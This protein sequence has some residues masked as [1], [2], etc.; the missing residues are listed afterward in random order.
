MKKGSVEGEARC[1]RAGGT[2]SRRSETLSG[3]FVKNG[4]CEKRFSCIWKL[5][6]S[7]MYDTL[8]SFQNAKTVI[9]L[10]FEDKKSYWAR[11]SARFTPHKSTTGMCVGCKWIPN[12]QDRVWFQCPFDVLTGRRKMTHKIWE[13]NAKTEKFDSGLIPFALALVPICVF[14]IQPKELIK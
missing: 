14:D 7:R 8:R 1:L 4:W 12:H 3:K 13:K 11:N 9:L 10:W 5:Y 2:P 6:F